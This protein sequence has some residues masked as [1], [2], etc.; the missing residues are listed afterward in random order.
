MQKG[1]QWETKRGATGS[2]KWLDQ[3]ESKA[4][5]EEFILD[6]QKQALPEKWWKAKVMKQRWSKLPDVGM[7]RTKVYEAWSVIINVARW[8]TYTTRMGMMLW[9]TLC[10]TGKSAE[11][12]V[13]QQAISSNNISCRKRCGEW[14]SK[15]SVG[16]KVPSASGPH[17]VLIRE[18]ERVCSLVINI[19]AVPAW[20]GSVRTRKLLSVKIKPFFQFKVKVSLVAE[21][22]GLVSN[23]WFAT[24][25]RCSACPRS[26]LF[27]IN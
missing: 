23:V 2:Q 8:R 14:R 7:P 6:G 12:A 9:L 13:F 25:A 11:R 16:L 18:K 19:A 5:K 17:I 21:A 3:G 15:D 20:D 4:E 26:R 27:T 22:L 10:Y 24:W 1:S